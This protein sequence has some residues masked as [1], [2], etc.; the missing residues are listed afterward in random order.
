M[1]TQN[2]IIIAV[3]SGVILTAITT[4]AKAIIDVEIL[5]NENKNVKEIVIE[6]KLN[7]KEFQKEHRKD[8]EEIKRRLK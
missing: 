5:K 7:Q 3:V 6:I 4:S 2:K 8:M 1:N